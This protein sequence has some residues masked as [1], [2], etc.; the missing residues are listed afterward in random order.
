MRGTRG[1]ILSVCLLVILTLAACGQPSTAPA[2]TGTTPAPT[3]DQSAANKKPITIGVIVPLSGPVAIWGQDAKQA[4]EFFQKEYEAGQRVLGGRPVKFVFAD[5]GSK[6][7][8]AAAAANKLISHDQVDLIMGT[9]LSGTALAVR[10]VTERQGT[11]FMVLIAKHPDITK[12]GQKHVLRTNS[13]VDMDVQQFLA[14][15]ENDVKPQRI[16]IAIERTDFGVSWENAIKQQWVDKPGK[17]NVVA[18]ESFEF[19]QSDFSAIISKMRLAKPDTVYMIS[20]NSAAIVQFFRQGQ[21]LG[22]GQVRKVLEPGAI[23]TSIVEKGGSAVEGLITAEL[24]HP[25]FDTQVNQDFVTRWK[26][27]FGSEPKKMHATTYAAAKILMEAIGKAGDPRA[28]DKIMQIVE[29]DQWQ[30]PLGPLKFDGNGQ[31]QVVNT[32]LVVKG[33]KIQPGG[34]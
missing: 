16:A 19:N 6:P 7:E 22:L 20:A 5:D 24:Y 14:Q 25:S 29:Q 9:V 23:E 32:P 8:E 28:Y 18:L 1:D 33:G 15:V 10:D 27:V 3:A 12:A 30:T 34:K 26:Q 2:P 11:L 13:T 17:P 4:V 31:A 21:E